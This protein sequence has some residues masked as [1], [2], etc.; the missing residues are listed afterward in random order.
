MDDEDDH[1]QMDDEEERLIA[2]LEV[3]RQ[4]RLKRAAV[5]AATSEM[6]DAVTSATKVL[7]RAIAMEASAGKESPVG[8]LD[9]ENGNLVTSMTVAAF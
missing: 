8:D 3:L 6:V 5:R 7:Q 9:E 2:R 1:Q 4:E